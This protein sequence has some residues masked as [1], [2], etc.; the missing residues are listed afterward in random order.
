MELGF[1]VLA[2]GHRFIPAKI[3]VNRRIWMDDSDRLPPRWARFGPG[4]MAKSQPRPR[5]QPGTWGR[6]R[7]S[8]SGC[9]RDWAEPK[10]KSES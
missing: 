9:F 1:G 2:G 4:G 6:A 5:L 8:C 10:A 3:A 7:G